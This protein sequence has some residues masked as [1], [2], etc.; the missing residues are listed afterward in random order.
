[1]G[2]PRRVLDDSHSDPL[3]RALLEALVSELSPVGRDA[4]A[5][6]EEPGRHLRSLLELREFPMNDHEDVLHCVRQVALA[7]PEAQQDTPHEADVRVVRPPERSERRGRVVAV[8]PPRAHLAS[9][10]RV[11][12]RS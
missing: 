9:P 6:R 1:M 2:D 12:H 3:A 7:N 4:R 11:F 10:Y 5:D 8:R